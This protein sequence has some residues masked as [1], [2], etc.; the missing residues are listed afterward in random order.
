MNQYPELF[1]PF[2]LGPLALR[3]R[4]VCSPLTTNLGTPEGL[5]TRRHLEFWK[6]RAKGG[7]GLVIL[8]S[9]Y[10]DPRGKGFA[11]QIGCHSDS[12]IPGLRAVAEAIRAEGAISALQIEHSGVQTNS[13]MAGG[14]PVAPSRVPDPRRT[15]IPHQLSPN[16]IE[17]TV[18]S[19]GQ[20]ARRI[21]DA[22]FDAVEIHGA[23]GYLVHQFLSPYFN[24][25][26]DSYGGDTQ[27]RVRFAREIVAH[28][29]GVVGSDY[30]ILFRISAVD[31]L[32]GGLEFEETIRIAE[33]LVDCGIDALD[34]SAGVGATSHLMGPPAG[35]PHGPLIDF[36]R[37]V[38]EV[39]R[40]PVIAVGRILDPGLANSIIESGKADLVALGRAL[41]ADPDWPNKAREGR[42]SEITTCIGC[43]GCNARSRRPDVICVVNSRVG[44][45]DRLDYRRAN[46]PKRVAVVGS[47]LGGLEAAR[48]AAERGHLVKV[49]EPDSHVGGLLGLRARTPGRAEFIEAVTMNVAALERKGVSV[50]RSAN[51]VDEVRDWMPNQLVDARSGA[52]GR[53]FPG[54]VR[55]L[56]VV[57]AVDVLRGCAVPGEQVVILGGGALGCEVGLH[58]AAQGFRIRLLSLGRGIATDTHPSIQQQLR[59]K[60]AE[61]KIQPVLQVTSV[62]EVASGLRVQVAESEEAMED[63]V[64]DAAIL[65]LGFGP[66]DELSSEILEVVPM[67]SVHVVGDAY[68]ASDLAEIVRAGALLGDNID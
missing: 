17:Q 44:L 53:S 18:E 24:R 16:E 63:L 31:G 15:E 42:T 28:V 9:A 58:L 46:H 49:W 33:M 1:S 38:R 66:P 41:I 48:V 29:R 43:C 3:N 14:R 7:A 13:Q 40:I 27:S 2:E 47:G 22:G 32:E 20:A 51:W 34:V 8:D 67:D 61:N 37:R 21:K 19:F 11:S 54:G 52:P 45:E 55:H 23:H 4:I 5:S 36:A 59:M 26:T 30:P 50:A 10:P 35:T 6:A 68:G 57:Q 56:P 25:R 65:A 64:V 39:V 62:D 60:L 12:T